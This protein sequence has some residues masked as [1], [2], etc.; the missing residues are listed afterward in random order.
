MRPVTTVKDVIDK[1]DDLQK[2]VWSD[3]L[4]TASDDVIHDTVEWL[5]HRDLKRVRKA[6]VE[7]TRME[8]RIR[9]Q[10]TLCITED[11]EEAKLTVAKVV[12]PYRESLYQCDDFRPILPKN[13][14]VLVSAEYPK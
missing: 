1:H 3:M 2:K 10:F 14:M 5:K 8:Q 12:N 11:F 4:R 13:P 9:K 6:A 7:Q